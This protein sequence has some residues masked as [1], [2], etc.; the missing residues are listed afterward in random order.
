MASELKWKKNWH[1]LITT[2]SYNI[3]YQITSSFNN[4]R[5]LEQRVS[6]TLDMSKIFDK[7]SL[8]KFTLT[9]IPNRFTI[10]MF[11]EYT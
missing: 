10:I 8:H 1:H 6:E 9:H 7:V 2:A 11:I 4:P 3:F 5:P